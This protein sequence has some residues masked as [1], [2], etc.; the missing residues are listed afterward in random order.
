MIH[1]DLLQ[2]FQA[3]APDL[4]RFFAKRV[5]CEHTAADL[6]QET[7]L[8]LTG[9]GRLES[10]RNVRAFLFQIADNLA[11]DHLR[12][13]TRFR[14]RY[15]GAPSAD[16]VAATPP[17]DR[18]LAAKQEWRIL[19]DAIAELPPKCRTAFWGERARST[20]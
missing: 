13:R 4:H 7:Y 8:R 14:R 1:G 20:R 3:C 15:A 18:E 10:V 12:S 16:L 6:T 11:I 2:L 17:P 5:R 9:L 19:Q